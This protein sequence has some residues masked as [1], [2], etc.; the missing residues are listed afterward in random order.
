MP[1]ILLIAPNFLS[2]FVMT[3]PVGQ[4]PF[5]QGKIPNQDRIPDP[6]PARPYDILYICTGLL[7]FELF[8]TN[9][10]QTA[11]LS[12]HPAGERPGIPIMTDDAKTP[13]ELVSPNSGQPMMMLD[14]AISVSLARINNDTDDNGIWTVDEADV[15]LPLPGTNTPEMHIQLVVQGASGIRLER[16]SYT[17]FIQAN[18][19]T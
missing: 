15:L 12:L 6:D 17:T 10:P 3:V 1:D 14:A 8:S 7:V 5:Q 19:V 13:L 2:T 4:F 9:G 18:T 11:L 16:V